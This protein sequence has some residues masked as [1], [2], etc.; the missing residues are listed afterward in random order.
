MQQ[1][2]VLITLWSWSIEPSVNAFKCGSLVPWKGASL[3]PPSLYRESK[4]GHLNILQ[5]FC[6]LSFLSVVCEGLICTGCVNVH[7]SNLFSNPLFKW[8]IIRRCWPWASISST[9]QASIKSDWVLLEVLKIDC[10]TQDAI[11]VSRIV[12]MV[13]S[14]SQQRT[15][16][17]LFSI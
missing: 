14:C 5:L 11:K 6:Y 17:V 2:S 3:I 13:I 4:E 8:E 7:S 1:D 15:R 16:P 10:C 9:A 12:I